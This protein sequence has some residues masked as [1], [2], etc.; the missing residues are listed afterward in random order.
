MDISQ[1][2]IVLCKPN[3]GK[4]IGAVCR[5]MFTMGLSRLRIVGKRSD[6]KDEEIRTLAVHAFHLWEKA[7]FF[8]RL[9]NAV[10]DCVFAAGT[11]RRGG[12]KR[13]FSVCSPQ[14]LSSRIFSLPSACRAAVVFGNERT[15]LTEDELNI[16]AFAVTI[17]ADAKAGSL[18]LSHAVQVIAYELYCAFQS[19]VRGGLKDSCCLSEAVSI[20]RLEQTVDEVTGSL[21]KIGFFSSGNSEGMKRFWLSILSRAALSEEETRY[22]EKIF[23]KAA[24]LSLKNKTDI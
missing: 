17:P 12:H 24:C 16:C 19:S 1:T 5:A 21:R 15:G 10:K 4:N 9:E 11:T 3:E 2:V 14:E 7:E 23:Y 18:N 13:S 6:Y 8:D 20:S 22:I